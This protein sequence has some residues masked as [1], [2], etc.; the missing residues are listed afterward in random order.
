MYFNSFVTG[1]IPQGVLNKIKD[2]SINQKKSRIQSDD[3][4]ISAILLDGFHR[5][6]DCR[7]NFAGLQQFTFFL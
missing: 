6:Y 7:K 3:S 5:K 4:I 1:Y 2:K